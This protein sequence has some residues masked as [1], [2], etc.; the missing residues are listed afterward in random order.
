MEYIS[1]EQ[2]S[3]DHSEY[4][5]FVNPWPPVR[6]NTLIDIFPLELHPL[7]LTTLNKGDKPTLLVNIMLS[8]FEELV[9]GEID[10]N[11]LL[12]ND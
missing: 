8:Q 12:Y 5:E 7:L 2:V 3:N 4:N 1:M 9:K 11:L 10:S 6:Y